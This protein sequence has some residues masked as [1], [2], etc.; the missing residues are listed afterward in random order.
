MSTIEI[1]R[2]WLDSA[3]DENGLTPGQRKLLD[4]WCKGTPYVGKTVPE[5]VARFVEKCR[6]Y[7]G[8]PADVQ[9]MLGR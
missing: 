1:T 9:N 8:M 6:G 7:R 2:E 3:G 5:N 4:I